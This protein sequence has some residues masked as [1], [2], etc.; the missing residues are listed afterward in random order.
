M[1][2]TI[3]GSSLTSRAHTVRQSTRRTV[4]VAG[5]TAIPQS[6]LRAGAASRT[7]DAVSSVL[8]S[9]SGAVRP[10]DDRLGRG[11]SAMGTARPA[12]TR[13]AAARRPPADK[14]GTGA[15]PLTLPL[16][17]GHLHHQPQ[18]IG[19]ART[20]DAG[21]FRCAPSVSSCD[22]RTRSSALTRVLRR[23]DRDTPRTGRRDPWPPR[24]P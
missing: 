3:A 9:I 24:R 6:L 7:R 12:S 5:V 1:A 20:T 10:H 8:I 21:Q 13:P 14:A 18:L 17:S 16:G 15:S 11:S 23:R 22:R 4:T 2:L 19:V